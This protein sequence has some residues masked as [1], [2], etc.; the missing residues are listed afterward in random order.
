[1]ANSP[2]V[3]YIV[4]RKDLV[5]ALKWSAGAIIAQACHATAAVTHLFHDD[6]HMKQYLTDLDAMHK[7]VL[8]TPDEESIK[9][10]E[11]DLIAHGIKHKLWV[12]QPENIPTCLV[13]KPYPK[14][15][16]QN[17]FQS[18]RLFREK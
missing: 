9:N 2:I 12:E 16:V 3:Q 15:D 17:F 10:L 1:M 5:K 18:L 13:V 8:E 14:E 6:P 7:I 4:V 11:S